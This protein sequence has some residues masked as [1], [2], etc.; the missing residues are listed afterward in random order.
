MDMVSK[1]SK[2][3][4]L[5]SLWINFVLGLMRDFRKV[6]W[7]NK[8]YYLVPSISIVLP[9]SIQLM[10]VLSHSL[11][12][13][14]TRWDRGLPTKFYLSLRRIVKS[15]LTTTGDQ[16]HELLHYLSLEFFAFSHT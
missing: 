6:L 3:Q 7:W 8:N 12:D 16:K 9:H 1:G 10:Y 14:F 13:P 15:H 2:V 5:C 11:D 4:R